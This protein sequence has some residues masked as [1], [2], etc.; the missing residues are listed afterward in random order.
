MEK[1]TFP[2]VFESTGDLT[3][4]LIRLLVQPIGHQ[5]PVLWLKHSSKYICYQFLLMYITPW[6]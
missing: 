1:S 4:K 5:R 3:V 6:F 2:S